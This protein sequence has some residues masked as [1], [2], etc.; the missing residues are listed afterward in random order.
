MCRT[1]D[2]VAPG[3]SAVPSGEQPSRGPHAL[4][5]QTA[6]G[7]ARQQTHCVTCEPSH[8]R[9]AWRGCH[10]AEAS[11]PEL[12]HLDAASDPSPRSWVRRQNVPDRSQ[13]RSP[14]LTTPLV[15]PLQAGPSC[16]LGWAHWAQAQ[17]ASRPMP[18]TRRCVRVHQSLLS[19]RH[20]QEE[21]NSTW[22]LINCLL[23]LHKHPCQMHT[24]ITPIS[25]I[26]RREDGGSERWRLPGVTRVSSLTSQDLSPSLVP[27]S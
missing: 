25:Q 1:Q 18:G 26:G 22:P 20:S 11:A 7:R 5:I 10:P 19:C 16:P 13:P 27:P 6:V 14:A 2:D 24:A 8:G 9:V 12:D 3:P 4:S 15:T 17:M 21:L 23:F